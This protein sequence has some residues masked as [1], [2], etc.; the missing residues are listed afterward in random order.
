MRDRKGSLGSQINPQSGI[1]LLQ[2]LAGKEKKIGGPKFP[3][4]RKGNISG[5]GLG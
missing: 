4:P 2:S 3:F 1:Q 5:A